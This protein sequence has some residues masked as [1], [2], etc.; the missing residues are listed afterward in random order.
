VDRNAL[1]VNNE[2]VLNEVP[3]PVSGI[4]TSH[5]VGTLS[6]N[7]ENNLGKDTHKKTS[8]EV[9]STLPI[10]PFQSRQW[11]LMSPLRIWCPEVLGCGL[12]TESASCSFFELAG[13]IHT[14]YHGALNLLP[15]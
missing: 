4:P 3:I 2:P 14:L 13:N 10:C 15:Q 11:A 1:S 6:V 12:D 9:P 8:V 7:E 5:A